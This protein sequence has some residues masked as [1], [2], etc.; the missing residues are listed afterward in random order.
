MC[1]YVVCVVCGCVVC[2]CEVCGV[3]VCGVR[4]VVCKCVVCGLLPLCADG[5]HVCLESPSPLVIS[6]RLTDYEANKTYCTSLTFYRKY[7]L[8]L[9]HLTPW[10]AAAGASMCVLHFACVHVCICACMRGYLGSV[11]V[12]SLQTKTTILVCLPRS[13]SRW[14]P[15]L[16]GTAPRASSSPGRRG[17][18]PPAVPALLTTLPHCL[19]SVFEHLC[20]DPF[21][22][23]WVK[24]ADFA[25]RVFVVPTP[26]PGAL[27]IVSAVCGVCCAVLSGQAVQGC[28][29]LTP[30]PQWAWCTHPSPSGCDALTPLSQ[31]AWCTH[32]PP[33]VGVVHSHPS[34]SGRGALIPLSQWV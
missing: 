7:G 8:T 30:L 9:T 27:R 15:R 14:S 28:G 13:A 1:R 20:P 24:I 22:E 32:T 19:C 10:T 5:A 29:A 25:Q 6:A 3:Q 23:F 34:R 18:L 12:P 16:L 26:P 11:S 21:N 2:R 17:G 33:P 4:C 31:W